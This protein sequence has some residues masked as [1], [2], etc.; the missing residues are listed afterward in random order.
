M[1]CKRD[2]KAQP[3]KVKDLERVAAVRGG[4]PALPEIT[5]RDPL[6]DTRGTISA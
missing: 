1:Q 2:V 4:P 3:H 5:D 6:P